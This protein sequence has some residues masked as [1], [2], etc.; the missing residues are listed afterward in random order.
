MSHPT[1][2]EANPLAYWRAEV[3]YWSEIKQLRAADYWREADRLRAVALLDRARREVARLESES[4][5]RP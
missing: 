3:E 2:T 1:Q 5:V 4:E